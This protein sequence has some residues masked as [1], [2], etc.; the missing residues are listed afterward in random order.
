M[1]WNL[2]LI[3]L[4]LFFSL[5]VSAECFSTKNNESSC[6]LLEGDSWCVKN[7]PTKPYAYDTSCL[8]KKLLARKDIRKKTEF[9]AIEATT[10]PTIQVMCSPTIQ[11][12]LSCRLNKADSWCKKNQP[13]K[14][15]AY[16]ASCIDNQSRITPENNLD[17]NESYSFNEEI[18]GPSLIA[19]LVF[20]VLIFKAYFD[21]YMEKRHAIK[22]QEL[23]DNGK[24]SIPVLFRL[25]SP[26]KPRHESLDQVD[27][28]HKGYDGYMT[29]KVNVNNI[30][31]NRK[32]IASYKIPKKL[33][34]SLS[35]I[36]LFYIISGLIHEIFDINVYSKIKDIGLIGTIFV[37]ILAELKYILTLI[38]FYYIYKNVN[39]LQEGNIVL[40]KLDGS[41][42]KEPDFEEEES[43]STLDRD[44]MRKQDT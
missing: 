10:N 30:T 2:Q 26:K 1:I 4:T 19:I 7:E 38:F 44:E 12:N 42:C 13:N 25:A 11:S 9:K 3:T 20:F 29:E 39:S 14:P 37:T 41:N 15:F 23:I 17:S 32:A 21:Q 35:L 8:T 36:F 22:M 33:F 16:K 27:S 6:R 28:L 43:V 24:V 34:V 5:S 31:K 18:I 40:E